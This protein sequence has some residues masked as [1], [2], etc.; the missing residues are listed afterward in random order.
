[1]TSELENMSHTAEIPVF[2][3]SPVQ[4]AGE[5]GEKKL[6]M[7]AFMMFTQASSSLESAFCRLQ[8][9][10]QRLTEELEAKNLELEKSLREKQEA[11]N[12]LRTI[13]ERLPCGVFVLDDKGALTLCNPMA[14]EVLNQS[15]CKSPGDGKRRRPS[16]SAEMRDYFTASASESGVK[17]EVEIPF[18]NGNSR[19]IVATS[20]APLTD[21]A[22]SRIGTLHII[23]DVTEVKALQEKNK[24]IEKLSAMGEMAVELAHEIRNPLAS[25]ELFASLL[26][27]ELSG[28]PV[29][30]AENIRIGIRSLNTIVSNMLHFANPLSP[31]FAEAS[32]HE[33]I[34]EIVKFCDPLISQRQVHLEM[35]LKAENYLISADRELFKQMML[36][37]IFN[38][39][40]AMPSQGSLSIGTR[41]IEME[42]GHCGGLELRIQDTGVG[43]S[44]EHLSRIFDPFFTTNKNGTGL[45]LSIVHQIVEKH[46]GSISVSSE[47]NWGTIFTIIFRLMPEKE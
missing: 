2:N 16:L 44:P 10:A 39:M 41:N 21:A 14:S 19:R 5:A 46:S 9:K 31:V 12:Y 33:M 8:E 6:L 45:G 22:G 43:I 35:D 7:E 34:R 47:V 30:W 1:M 4:E 36:N 17:E 37:L 15:H 27:K 28:D 29:R 11:Q 18:T 32:V 3:S 38:A 42:A 26:V 40:K 13:L 24:H 23:R 25:I 20:G